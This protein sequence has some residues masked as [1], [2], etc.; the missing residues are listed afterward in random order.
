[1]AYIGLNINMAAPLL[2]V[3]KAYKKT[4]FNKVPYKLFLPKFGTKVTNSYKGCVALTSPERPFVLE[5]FR[6]FFISIPFQSLNNYTN[7]ADVKLTMENLV[8]TFGNKSDWGINPNNKTMTIYLNKNERLTVYYALHIPEKYVI[9]LPDGSAINNPKI[10]KGHAGGDFIV[11]R[12]GD[13]IG[14]MKVVNGH[15]FEALYD[16]TNFTEKHLITMDNAVDQ[17][18]S[19][20]LANM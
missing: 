17:V 16:H 15:E 18:L 7:C 2:A 8:D 12:A 3:K 10:P 14:N 4:N 5:L 19:Y 1:M 6:G 13:K 9:Q 11:I 20:A